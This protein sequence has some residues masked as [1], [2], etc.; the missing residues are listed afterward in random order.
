MID[1][2]VKSTISLCIL[3]IAYH[4]FLEKEKMFRFNRYF[5][6]ISLVFS[7]VVPFISF[8]VQKEIPIVRENAIPFQAIRTNA[9]PI[10]TKEKTI[11]SI[12]EQTDFWIPISWVLYG[13]ITLVLSFRFIRNIYLIT[14]ISKFYKVVE[15]KNT[16]LV[17]LSEDILPYTFWNTIYV[18]QKDFENREIEQELFTHEIVHVKQK[19]TID[20]I[21]VEILK[22]VFWFNPLFTFYKKAIQ[23]NHEFLA[24]ENVI[25]EHRDLSFYQNLLL[26]KISVCGPVLLTSNL[27]FLATKKRFVMMTKITSK[28]KALTTKLAL[29]G[30]FIGLVLMLCIQFYPSNSS[31]SR[32]EILQDKRRDYIYSGIRI[33]VD[34]QKE[35]RKI[36]ELYDNLDT[37]TK[38]KYIGAYSTPLITKKT[39]SESEFENWK[40]SNQYTIWLNDKRIIDNSNL[41]NLNRNEIAYFADQKIDLRFE[42]ISEEDNTLYV[43][44]QSY[45]KKN[46]L[47]RFPQKYNKGEFKTTWVKGEPT[48]EQIRIMQESFQKQMEA[49]RIKMLNT[50]H[51]YAAQK[52]EKSKKIMDTEI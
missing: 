18:S 51:K 27:N 21:F 37:N 10:L 45:F 32:A 12:K 50:S 29:F 13:V 48:E 19:H 26:K 3:L 46:K 11:A 49:K 30:L 14:S 34:N 44:T 52:L 38:R 20:V 40:N 15:Y 6:L 36:N 7:I 1:F 42:K 8:D 43:Y 28:S 23:L 41:S 25:A 24:D 33:I 35:N 22:T 2:F 47:E 4:L 9:F 5:L 17:L 31:A 16:R 39:P